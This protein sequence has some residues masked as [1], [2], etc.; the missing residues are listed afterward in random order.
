EDN[1]RVL[2]LDDSMFSRNRSKKVELLA[3]NYDHASGKY[4]KGFRMLTLGWSDGFT[5]IPLAKSFLSSKKK[6]NRLS[7]ADERVDKRT[8]GYKRRQEAQK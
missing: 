5:F 1:E 6:A 8:V 2:I 7:E 4:M 3:K